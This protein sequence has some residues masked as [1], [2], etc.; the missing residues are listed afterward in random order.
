M[1]DLLADFPAVKELLELIARD[2]QRDIEEAARLYAGDRARGAQ[3]ITE[4]RRA[5]AESRARAIRPLVDAVCLAS[6]A[7]IIIRSDDVA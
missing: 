4:I 2:E 3:R 5:Y 1:A 7:P 6:T